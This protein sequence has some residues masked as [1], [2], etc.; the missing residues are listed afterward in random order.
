MCGTG[1]FQQISVEKRK[2][3]GNEGITVFSDALRTMVAQRNKSVN[4]YHTRRNSYSSSRE[5]DAF[6]D[7]L[8]SAKSLHKRKCRTM[9]DALSGLY[10][11]LYTHSN[12]LYI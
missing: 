7:K 12:V 1:L 6:S 9:L 5:H 4:E 11:S 10:C 2:R 3:T 8:A